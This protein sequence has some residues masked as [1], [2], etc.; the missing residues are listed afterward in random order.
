MQWPD[1]VPRGLS[2]FIP[3]TPTQKLNP[4]NSD[5]SQSSVEL[6]PTQ[7]RQNMA[8]MNNMPL[9]EAT[10]S[11]VT[12]TATTS[13]DGFSGEI[14]KQNSTSPKTPFHIHSPA[15][16][17]HDAK[18]ALAEPE[19][20][21][22]KYIGSRLGQLIPTRRPA[23]ANEPERRAAAPSEETAGSE[24]ANTSSVSP[25]VVLAI[26]KCLAFGKG[27]SRLLTCSLCLLSLLSRLFIFSSCWI[28]APISARARAFQGA[29]KIKQTLSSIKF[30][31]CI[32]PREHKVEKVSPEEKVGDEKSDEATIDPPEVKSSPELKVLTDNSDVHERP[33]VKT[34]SNPSPQELQ[35]K[36]PAPEEKVG[37]EKSKEV[38]IAPPEVKSIP[39]M[40]DTP[41]LKV[42]VDRSD[43]KDMPKVK[44]S[45]ILSPQEIQFKIPVYSGC[46]P[47]M[48]QSWEDKE[49]A[50]TQPAAVVPRVDVQAPRS[51]TV[52]SSVMTLVELF[53][54][55]C[56]F[57][58]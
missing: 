48:R 58:V 19:V 23:A 13:G 25:Q 40:K 1:F 56:S 54:S 4:P 33:E 11:L 24:S 28:Q 9:N 22:L 46:P 3:P 17:T 31:S 14:E 12:A 43:V 49:P 20:P 21:I 38:K 15:T 6:A 53:E 36:M 57:S 55:G 16:K 10:F 35:A 41:E 47:W 32:K 39:V 18:T 45:S 29:R 44:T 30:P 2:L 52:S 42:L 50:P 37:G 51:T 34:P 8:S 5:H 27:V 7:G 26:L